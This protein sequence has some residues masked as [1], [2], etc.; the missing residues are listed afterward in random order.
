[1]PKFLSRRNRSSKSQPFETMIVDEKAPADVVTE[2][3]QD[4]EV[5]GESNHLVY[6]RQAGEWKRMKAQ[7]AQ[8]KKQR[9]ALTKKQRDKKKQISQE[10]KMLVSSIRD[11]HDAELRELGIIPPNR[12]EM[13][14]DNEDLLKD[15]DY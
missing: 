14:Q 4:D 7:V 2:E 6:K 9:K 15:F 11:R 13:M 12:S 3:Q 8:L 1:M 10:I 5:S